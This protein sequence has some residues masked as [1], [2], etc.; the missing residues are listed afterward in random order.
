MFRRGLI[1]GRIS[2]VARAEVRGY[3]PTILCSTVDQQPT[4]KVASHGL[5]R[6]FLVHMN[7]GAVASS[8]R[9]SMGKSAYQRAHT[10]AHTMA[11]TERTSNRKY[12]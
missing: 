3:E 10:A 5:L 1:N 7:R 9:L 4:T 2:T 11:H 12:P 8:H 6:F